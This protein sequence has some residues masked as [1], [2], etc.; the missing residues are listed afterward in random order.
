MWIIINNGCKG[1]TVFFFLNFVQT[2]QDKATSFKA[3]RNYL[4][5]DLEKQTDKDRLAVR[6][7]LVW[8]SI[9]EEGNF[10]SKAA[11]KDSPEGFLSL[12][13]KKQTL[14][15]TFFTVLCR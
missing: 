11:N 2:P 13:A 4:L 15:S 6:A 9:Q 8:L 5:K 14:F 12:L 10:G 1:L 7:I 3:L